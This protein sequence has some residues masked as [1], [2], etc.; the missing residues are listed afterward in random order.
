MP[1]VIWLLKLVAKV[2]GFTV[3]A[4]QKAAIITYNQS[5]RLYPE[6]VKA[7]RDSYRAGRKFKFE[8]PA[9]DDDGDVIDAEIVDV[10][11]KN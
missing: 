4:G 6:V 1:V 9:L 2:L 7:S 8:M 11:P 3:G 5:T 10:T